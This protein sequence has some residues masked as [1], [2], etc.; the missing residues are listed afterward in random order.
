MIFSCYLKP[1]KAI[2]FD[3]IPS[4]VALFDIVNPERD[5][6][7][8]RNMSSFNLSFAG[9]TVDSANLP[10]N[11]IAH[12]MQLGFSTAIKN[13]IA[14]VKAG[15]LGNGATPWSDD[16]IANES[17][18][19]GLT[20]YGR[21]EETATAICAAIQR[22]MFE[23]ILSGVARK[24]RAS[25]PRLSDDDKLRLTVEIEILAAKA[26]EKGKTLPKRTTKE[27]KAAFEAFVENLRQTNPGFVAA[28]DK[29]FAARKKRAAALSDSLDDIF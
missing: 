10:E 8:S 20:R 27:E 19:I 17:T 9:F 1:I 15:V 21:D 25:S 24:S 12:L 23:S 6:L 29:E 16:D 3:L 14:G 4:G 22:E 11:S 7:R 13:S 28:V 18:R 5:I 2:R 26:K